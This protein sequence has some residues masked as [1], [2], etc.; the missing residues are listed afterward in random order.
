MKK[1]F[2]TLF[3]L[4][5]LTVQAQYLPNGSFD[6]WKSSCGNTEAFGEG[7]T[8]SPKGGEMRQRPGVEPT[9]W[10]GSS[11]NQKVIM[12]KSQQ[13]V[14]NDNNSVKMQNVYIGVGTLGSVAPGF[15]TFGTPWVYATSTIKNCD[16]GTYGGVQFTNK[17]DAIKGR[18]KR[19]D[20]TGE[21]SHIIVYMWNGTYVSNV[22]NK[23]SASQPRDNVDRAIFG[24]TSATQN[25]TL[26]A[27]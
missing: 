16:G 5:A 12:T 22:G 18:F 26:V 11:I 10:N 19:E 7:G 21:N 1:I 4:A 9:D 17:P 3:A 8:T 25:G 6:S 13:L 2:T 23:N 27:K 24:K 14:Y 15:I 20:T